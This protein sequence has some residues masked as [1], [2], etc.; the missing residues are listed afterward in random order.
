M[1]AEAQ[2][3]HAVSVVTLNLALTRCSMQFV[4][5]HQYGVPC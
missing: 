2:T 1:L 3:N 5:G 4:H